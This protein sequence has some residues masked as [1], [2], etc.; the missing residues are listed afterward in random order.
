MTKKKID[1]HNRKRSSTKKATSVASRSLNKKPASR[2]KSAAIIWTSTLDGRYTVAVRRLAESR[3]ELT[4]H[5]GDKLLHREEVGLAYGAIFGPDVDDL[6]KW[7]DIATKVVDNLNAHGKKESVVDPVASRSPDH[8]WP[9]YIEGEAIGELRTYGQTARATCSW[10]GH[11]MTDERGIPP[12][13][14]MLWRHQAFEHHADIEVIGVE[15][16][17][18][19]DAAGIKLAVQIVVKPK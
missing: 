19:I 10:C 11:S 9:I 13:L 1:A 3:G 16:V 12:V 7:Q 15:G 14:K 6:G 18:K 5:D 17:D 2:R 8:E 4:I